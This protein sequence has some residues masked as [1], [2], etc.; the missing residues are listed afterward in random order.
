MKIP[1]LGQHKTFFVMRDPRDI[2]VSWYFSTK[3]A[4]VIMGEAMLR[5]RKE[6][7]NLSINDGM[8][9][10]IEFL[11]KVGRFSSMRSWVDAEEND[12]NV[13]LV[14]YEDLVSQGNTGLKK[15]FYDLDIQ[16]PGKVLEDLIQAYSFKRLS[17]RDKGKENQYSHLRKGVSGDWRNYFDSRIENRFY[18]LCGDLNEY[19]GYA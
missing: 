19:L 17:G 16:I 10:A 14:R 6:L 4:H 3:H 13:I 12:P 5:R 9:Y 8:I 1:K 18:E 15:L 2:V 7:N 11:S